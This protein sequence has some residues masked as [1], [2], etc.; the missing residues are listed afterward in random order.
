MI[1]ARNPEGRKKAIAKL[2]PHQR[3]DFIGIFQALKVCRDDPAPG[4]AAP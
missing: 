3:N 1:L 4:S 2:L